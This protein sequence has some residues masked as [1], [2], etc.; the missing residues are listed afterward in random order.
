[1]S[2]HE[3]GEFSMD[4]HHNLTERVA[5]G[6]PFSDDEWAALKALYDTEIRYTDTFV[7][8]LFDLIRR[9]FDDTIVVVTADHG[10]HF[11]ER[12][13]LAHRYALDDPLLHVPLVTW[14]LDAVS[15][16]TPVQH[17]DVMRTLLELADADSS[18]VNG[19]D[20]RSETREFAVSQDSDVS[21]EPIL[22]FNPE[23]DGERFF[24]GV[25]H[26]IPERTAIT[27]DSHR[28]VRGVD[29]TRVLYRLP[30]EEVSDDISADEPDLVEDLDRK[31]ETWLADHPYVEKDRDSSRQALT[32]DTKD[33]LVQMGYLDEDL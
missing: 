14:G 25:D 12:G 32:D 27:T 1:M 2:T 33:R 16:E 5:E 20:L 31:L 4:V 11:G 17:S 29:G 18:F 23:F 24:P 9:R 15:T 30:D 3:A 26:T 10:E 8:E 6:C 13:A 21:I 7:G 22:E 28:Y 19:V